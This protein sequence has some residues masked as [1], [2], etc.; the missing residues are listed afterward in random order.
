MSEPEEGGERDEWL[1]R[2]LEELRRQLESGAWPEGARRLADEL[3][4]LDRRPAETPVDETFQFALSDALEGVDISQRYPDFYRQLLADPALRNQFLEAI[5]I[6]LA[7]EAGTLETLPDSLMIDL[8]FLR[9]AAPSTPAG[10]AASQ[11]RLTWQRTAR[12]LEAVL[13]A[14]S[15]PELV[16]RDAGALPE[17]DYLTILDETREMAG[18]EIALLLG[19]VRQPADPTTLH[20]SLIVSAD[21]EPAAPLHAEIRWGRYETETVVSADGLAELP[22]VPLAAVTDETG[23]VGAD[24]QLVISSYSE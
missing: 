14:F 23:G 5:E 18:R 16:L 13:G 17:D 11:W 3:R 22:P 7:D 1:A 2:R 15:S 4:W 20:L 19:A 24:L 12:Q 21:P 10:S 6:I 9:G 8:T